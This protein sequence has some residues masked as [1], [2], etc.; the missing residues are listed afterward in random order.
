MQFVPRREEEFGFYVIKEC[1][2][3]AGR[4]ENGQ[5]WYVEAQPGNLAI[6]LNSEEFVV[7]LGQFPYHHYVHPTKEGKD[8]P[9]NVRINGKK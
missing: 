8:N 6:K 3:P 1:L 7:Y 4:D 2:L 5:L 9:N